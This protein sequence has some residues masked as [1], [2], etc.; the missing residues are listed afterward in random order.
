MP[1]KLI[2]PALIGTTAPIL[3]NAYTH[4][5]LNSL[6]IASGFPGDAPEGNKEVKCQEW[7][8][9]ANNA[10]PDAL[11]LFGRLIG[12]FME[13]EP[14]GDDQRP[15]IA[16][17]LTRAGL[18][19]A[20]GG[21]ILGAALTGPSRSLSERL[22]REGIPAVETEYQ[23]AY[24]QVEAD[25]PAAVTAACAILETV[26]K[27]YLVSAGHDLPTKQVLGS[28]WSATANHLGLSP[29]DMV[30]DDL[31]RAS[32]TELQPCALTRA[33]PMG[34]STRCRWWLNE[35]TASSPATPA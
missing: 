24:A 14:Y 35:S 9:R 22:E 20:R 7:L 16:A 11:D 23:R 8:R 28:L 32:P 15:A 34:T 21:V 18:S 27:T 2:P 17:A 25:P 6:F 31:N 19:Y 1:S 4:A 30:A 13:T 33:P 29:K 10:C 5:G 12:E 3:A 26:C